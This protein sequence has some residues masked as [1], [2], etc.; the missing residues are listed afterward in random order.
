M[1]LFYSFI[2]I[3]VPAV[4]S[5]QVLTAQEEAHKLQASRGISG[6]A[7]ARD[8]VWQ[9]GQ[10][11]S[12]GH[13]QS[14]TNHQHTELRPIAGA[15]RMKQRPSRVKGVTFVLPG[16]RGTRAPSPLGGRAGRGRQS[17]VAGAQRGKGNG[18]SSRK[19][20]RHKTF[21]A[22]AAALQ[23][24]TQVALDTQTQFLLASLGSH[25]EKRKAYM[26]PSVG[27]RVVA[28]RP[29]LPNALGCWMSCVLTI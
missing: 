10:K 4:M 11:F 20:T 5:T 6:T 14:G 23:R 28:A 25:D 16:D 27:T 7:I 1:A 3:L 13:S 2:L 12:L 29:L 9:S 8:T 18:T 22:R 17:A 21:S 24:K 19:G 15:P 26:Y